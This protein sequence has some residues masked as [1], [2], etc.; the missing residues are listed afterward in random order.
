MQVIVR[1]VSMQPT[2]T[3]RC[4]AFVVTKLSEM[5]SERQL[6]HSASP[7]LVLSSET[8]CSF[9]SKHRSHVMQQQHTAQ[10]PIPPA[11]C[12]K[13]VAN[14]P[15]DTFLPLMT[16]SHL[17]SRGT[18]FLSYWSVTKT[19][20]V[21]VS[22]TT[23]VHPICFICWGDKIDAWISLPRSV[24]CLWNHLTSK[25]KFCLTWL[26]MMSSLCGRCHLISAGLPSDHFQKFD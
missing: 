25:K 12:M 5:N 7:Q 18:I 16:L 13:E 20:G 10:C 8:L 6:F 21:F 23:H 3:H 9:E 22:E 17:L 15:C 4:C 24:N 19:G 11:V 14:E 1:A 26:W 2:K